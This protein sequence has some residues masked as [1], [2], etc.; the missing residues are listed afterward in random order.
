MYI[1]IMYKSPMVMFMSLHCSSVL[2]V[3][4]KVELDLDLL[5]HLKPPCLF[6]CFDSHT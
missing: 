3:L 5:H 2:R 1:I 6:P 4:V